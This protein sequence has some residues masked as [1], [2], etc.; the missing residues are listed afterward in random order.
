MPWLLPLSGRHYSRIRAL[1]LP[2][3]RR[4]PPAQ[5]GH[6]P[7][8]MITM[9]FSAP[10]GGLLLAACLLPIAATPAAAAGVAAGYGHS[11]AVAADGSVRSW[12]DD[13]WGGLGLGRSLATPSPAVVQGLAN[14]TAIAAGASFTAV[15]RSDGTV[16]TW[17]SNENGQL[18][19]GSFVSRSIPVQVV[20]LT[21]VVQISAGRT[22]MMARRSDGSVWAWG[23]NNYGELGDDNPQRSTPAQV[24]GVFSAVEISAGSDHSLARTGDGAVWAWGRN[25]DGQ[26]GDG[27]PTE[28]YRGRFQPARIAGL[29]NVVQISGG[30]AHSLALRNDGSVWAWGYNE[31]GAVGDG[32]T[33]RRAVPTQVS[34]LSSVVQ[35]SA[36]YR[37]SA[38][39]RNDG[40]VWVWGD[41]G[42]GQLGDGFYEDRLVPVQLPGLPPTVA[43][44]AAGF[45]HSLALTTDGSLFAWGY[46]G[47]GALG[48]G[49]TTTR[50]TPGRV[51]GMPAL[52]AVA[53]GAGHSVGM[54][55]NGSVL[56]W[57]DNASG[58]LG[59]AALTFR[60][61]PSVVPGLA[62]ITAITAGG[63]VAF[64]LTAQ[65]TLYEW[66]NL[67]GYGVGYSSP[68]LVPNLTGVTGVSA[69][70]YH[71][72]AILA[73][74]TLR[75]WGSNWRGR[76]GDGGEYGSMVPL[77]VS[78]LANV[79]R[80]SAGLTHTLAVRADGTVWAWGE[81]E[82]GQLG[83]G[84]TTDRNVPVRVAGVANAIDVAAGPQHSLALLADGTVMAWGRNYEGQLG[85]GNEPMRLAPM[86]VP[87]LPAATAIAAG[88]DF[89]LALSAGSVWAWGVNY[90]GGIGCR[91]CD[92]RNGPVRLAGIERVAS[93]STFAFHVLAMRD[94]G[95]VYSWAGNTLG[96][97]GDGTLIDRDYPVVVLHEGGTGSV[98]A[99]DWFLDL[100]PAV[101]TQIPPDDVPS[102]LVVASTA[103]TRVVADIRYRA[104]DVGTSVTTF[105]FA[106]AP[107]TVIKGS[108]KD[109]DPRF[110]WKARSA[111]GKDS[112]V[113]CALAQL[114]AQGQ[115]VAVSA[116]SLQAFVSGVLSAQ[117][118][119]VNVLNAITPDVKGATFFVG[120]GPNGNAMLTNGTTR[121][122]VSV[123]GD[124][125]CKPQSP[126]TGWWY[127]P[128]EGGRG[129]S[130]EAR[131]N[132]LFFAA[133]HYEPDG[134]ATWNFAGG[135]T[136]LDGSLFTSDFLSASGG[137]TLTG[138]YRLP[139]LANAGSITL[140]FSNAT[141][142]TMFWPGG[143][144]AIERQPILPGGLTTPPQAGL[145]EGGWWWNPAESGRGFFIE[146]QNGWVDIAG[147]M[148]DAAGRPTWY[149]AAY[150]TPNPMLI[151]GNWWTFGGGQSMGGAYRPATRTSD[152]VGALRV[153]FS[154]PTTATMQ[155]P[156]G[157][158]MPLVRQ[159]F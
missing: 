26:L 71:V 36:A 84:S 129:F 119:S 148:Y 103:A 102:F 112:H 59:N 123:A 153:E 58:Q 10:L 92:G 118:Q 111:D 54:R 136:S 31:H 110:G 121:G 3:V 144:V 130:I 116:A 47:S 114:N 124:V 51:E 154:G 34:G 75:A 29:E 6:V 23:S 142:G 158:R 139:G 156:D 79:T 1:N 70:G 62:G 143:A 88:R 122:V 14:V 50:T 80:V 67:L 107:T 78:N 21:G 52:A 87:G 140:A 27:T 11:L 37:H 101:P 125:S 141:H 22:H 40:T 56:T 91:G 43:R 38:A 42:N 32:T 109:A 157:R 18:G 132:R 86:R 93:I 131:G 15:L 28:L 120:Y 150:P 77:A 135:A 30:G 133:F 45:L 99:S 106:L 89:S 35:V 69:G 108:L 96:Q 8:L 147:Y 41:G 155:L 9:R 100:V 146:W 117:T 17:G 152:N 16:W 68:R 48:D 5:N 12:G 55:A 85:V 63:S 82:Y 115:L 73:D 95:A 20:G 138:P 76:L 113:Q 90:N 33:A 64:A 126:Q 53:V 159:A 24:A 134:R 7:I 105:V 66:G 46:N 151:E 2:V 137:Q 4:P 13:S 60:S 83:D 25:D 19:D 149:I 97:L 57:G 145:P 74:R 49:T 61:T 128:A 72:V 81:N 127:N 98:A 104:Q 94:D 44:I 39:L 65:G